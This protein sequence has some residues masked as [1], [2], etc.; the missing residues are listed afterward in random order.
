MIAS[1]IAILCWASAALG[2][3]VPGG[4]GPLAELRLGLPL[5]G[6]CSWPSPRERAAQLSLAQIAPAGGASGNWPAISVGALKPL[7]ER[8]GVDHSASHWPGRDQARQIVPRRTRIAG[9]AAAARRTAV[10]LGRIDP[11]QPHPAD[12]AT[13]QRVAIHRDRGDAEEGEAHSLMP[14]SAFICAIAHSA[15]RRLRARE[16][17][18]RSPAR[19]YASSILRNWAQRSAAFAPP[20]SIVF[21]WRSS[22]SAS[23]EQAVTATKPNA[24]IAARM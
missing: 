16:Y 21:S 14:I 17:F 18:S 22:C 11:R 12:P 15:A 8:I 9:R 24:I 6:L 1:H 20:S 4:S 5:V 19:E 13:P 10:Q 7:L 23:L 3:V 2:G